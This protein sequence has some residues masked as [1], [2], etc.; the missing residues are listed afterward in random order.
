MKCGEMNE[1]FQQYFKSSQVKYTIWY[2]IVK[3]LWSWPKIIWPWPFNPK[4]MFIMWQYNVLLQKKMLRKLFDR[5]HKMYIFAL[6]NS[7]P[8]QWRNRFKILHYG[9][10]MTHHGWQI[11]LTSFNRSQIINDIGISL[12]DICKHSTLHITSVVKN[13]SLS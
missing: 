7:E 9:R 8:S 1:F 6:F 10:P 13:N 11:N 3:H 4:Q 5:I 12:S 2:Y